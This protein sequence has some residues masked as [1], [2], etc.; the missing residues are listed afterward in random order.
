MTTKKFTEGVDITFPEKY[1][2]LT[3]KRLAKMKPQPGKAGRV[4]MNFEFRDPKL[5]KKHKKKFTKALKLRVR[6]TPADEDRAKGA[7]NLRLR[8]NR[9]A[10]WQTF[11]HVRMKHHGKGKGGYGEV[12]L[13]DW[14]P[15]LAW[16]P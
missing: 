4:V 14:D 10:G 16:F 13:S 9:G 7:K 8:Y 15:A 11:R 12:D 1:K 2:H 5:K 6:Y 3:V